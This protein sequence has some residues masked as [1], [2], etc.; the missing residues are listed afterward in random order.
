MN[1]NASATLALILAMVL[2]GGAFVAMKFAVLAYPPFFVVFGRLFV[3][4]VMFCLI[5]PRIKPQGLSWKDVKLMLLMSFFEPCLYF[6]CEGY[7]LKYTSA[8]LASLIVS[9]MPL[10]VGLAAAFFLGED[11][12]VTTITGFIV[13][14]GG[15]AVLTLAGRPD[16]HSP[17]P[18]LG[19]ALEFL[20]MIMGTGYVL[21]ARS[22]SRRCGPLFM[23]AVQSFT[24]TLFFMPLAL[25][26]VRKYGLNW[27]PCA[28]GAIL[29]LGIMVN[30]VAY[31]CYNYGIV[32]TPA[33]RAAAFT[34]LIPLVSVIIG[35]AFLGET[36]NPI[37]ISGALLVLGG[38]ILSQGGRKERA[39][40]P[41]GISKGSVRLESRV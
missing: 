18:L 24:G 6:L 32:K 23:A 3:A 27:D 19:N 21:F 1:G 28:A 31:S 33:A 35:W 10:M 37:Q 4:S 2:W 20:A 22:L 8:G 39:E 40:G 38:I 25:W 11:L 13:A 17:N 30:A 36:M 14:M 34:N 5:M 12:S 7:A 16:F 9:A 15:V 29:F 26:Q 41:A